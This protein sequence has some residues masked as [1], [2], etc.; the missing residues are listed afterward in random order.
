MQ[1][2]S[3]NVYCQR[4]YSPVHYIEHEIKKPFFFLQQFKETSAQNKFDIFIVKT[5]QVKV[6]FKKCHDSPKKASYK[7]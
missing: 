6:I 4:V 1:F 7:I 2:S 3:K 5:H